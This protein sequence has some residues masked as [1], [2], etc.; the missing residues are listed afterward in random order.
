MGLRT[1]TA[2]A[3]VQSGFAALGLNR[4]T[5]FL[6]DWNVL[7]FETGPYF[8]FTASAELRRT[9]Q[10]GLLLLDTST[11]GRRAGSRPLENRTRTTI[12]LSSGGIVETCKLART[13]C[14]RY[15]YK[16]GCYVVEF[17]PFADSFEEAAAGTVRS[18]VSYSL[19]LDE[20]G[21]GPVQIVDF[22]ALVYGLSRQPLYALGDTTTQW[23]ATSTGPREV[24]IRVAEERK[25]RR[26]CRDLDLK[27]YRTVQT[28]EL[29]VR[30]TP[31][32][33]ELGPTGFM[34]LMGPTAIWIDADT[35]TPV[36]VDGRLPN[37]PGHLELDLTGFSV[38]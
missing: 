12:D 38:R 28:R 35:R 10:N 31:A 32:D 15:R 8:M 20:A 26:T 23:L 22:A 4:E 7:R 25:I 29:L 13:K 16:N 24:Q 36:E 37:L 30:V 34:G 9:V 6:E 18:S 19:P 1:A 11:I 17:L 27:R 21:R 5:G 14:I 2:S 3:M 33:Q